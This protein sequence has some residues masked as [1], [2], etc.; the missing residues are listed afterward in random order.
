MRARDKI[1]LRALSVALGKPNNFLHSSQIYYST[2][3]LEYTVLRLVWLILVL[4]KLKLENKKKIITKTKVSAGVWTRDFRI[5][6]T[7][8]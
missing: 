7:M 5:S 1:Q 3:I 4:I 2:I 8:L 6:D